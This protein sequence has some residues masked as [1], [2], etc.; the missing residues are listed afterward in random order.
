ME[1]YDSYD[2]QRTDDEIYRE[3]LA[4]AIDNEALLSESPGR[5]HTKVIRDMAALVR[6]AKQDSCIRQFFLLTGRDPD[7][8]LDKF[9]RRA[10]TKLGKR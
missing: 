2:I 5:Y 3:F 6:V 8:M 7:T 9:F 1:K 10:V 4:V